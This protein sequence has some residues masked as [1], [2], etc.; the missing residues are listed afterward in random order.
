MDGWHDLNAGELPKL[1]TEKMD[2][3][4]FH[5]EGD[6]YVYEENL[7][8]GDFHLLVRVTRPDWT[9][10]AATYSGYESSWDGRGSRC[11]GRREEM[12]SG[13]PHEP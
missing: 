13:I 1:R 9:G 8:D 2:G 3:F 4:G 12:L 10:R 6:T 7:L 11:V 5:R